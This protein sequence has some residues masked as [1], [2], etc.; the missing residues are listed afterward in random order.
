VA[1]AGAVVLAAPAAS[2]TP[3]VADARQQAARLRSAVD[4]LEVAAER[5]TE[6]YDGA[7]ERLG[8]AVQRYLAAETAL[9]A[10]AQQSAAARDAA[11]ARVRA[12]YES[13]GSAT[14]YAS[15]LESASIAEALDR[16]RMADNVIAQSRTQVATTGAAV[17]RL[18]ALRSRLAS[19]AA[20]QDRLQI[21]AA[22]K[23]QH[24]RD[25]LARRQQ[26]LAAADQRVKALVAAAELA[27][28]EAAARAFAERLAAAQAR[29]LAAQEA[30]NVP[31]SALSAS[32]TPP[33]AVAAAALAAARTRLGDP[34]VWGATGPDTFDCSGLTGWAYAQAGLQLPRTAAEQWY[35]GPH[36]SLAELAPGDLLF[37]A[38][39]TTNPATI[40]HVGL[41]IGNGQMIAAPHTGAVVTVQPVYWTGYIGAV[42][43]TG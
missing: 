13:G 10:T 42:R 9:D 4:A 20:E 34:Y 6:D 30:G 12:L 24:V 37:W 1:L 41:Y 27:K 33:N 7:Q 5:A 35:A 11:A 22:S 18:Q 39:D 17:R 36:P 14:L 43:P 16:V 21:Q 32:T 28:A 23:A 15:A 40:H 3:S 19:L 31:P 38:T 29:A 26:L 8:V 2:A 25:L